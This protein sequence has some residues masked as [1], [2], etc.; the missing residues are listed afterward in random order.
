MNP[1]HGWALTLETPSAARYL[2]IIRLTSAGAAAEAG[3]TAEQIDDVK[4]AVDELC[5]L[6]MAA[7]AD[8]DRLAMRFLADDNGIIIEATGPSGGRLEVDD[9]AEAILDATVDELV[10]DDAGLGA[11]FRLIKHRTGG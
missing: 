11:G 10:L 5:S 4:I 1:D 6:V 7:S 9:L 8:T 2:H 3:L